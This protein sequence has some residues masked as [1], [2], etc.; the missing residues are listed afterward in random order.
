M[1]LLYVTAAIAAMSLGFSALAHSQSTPSSS[2]ASTP[3]SDPASTPASAPAPAADPPASAP[4]DPAP[5]PTY[6]KGWNA[7]KCAAAAAKHKMTKPGDCPPSADA[8]Q[9]S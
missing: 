6:G 5:A 8:P 4:A 2:P 3:P 9:K 7:K 1:R